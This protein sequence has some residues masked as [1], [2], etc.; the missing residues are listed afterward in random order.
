M[1]QSSRIASGIETRGFGSTFWDV[2]FN[3]KESSTKCKQHVAGQYGM[4]IK[5]ILLN[6][7]FPRF[8]SQFLRSGRA[9]QKEG[10]CHTPESCSCS[11]SFFDVNPILA[12]SM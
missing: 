6:I 3:Y 1:Q 9:S 5:S 12:F 10:G 8:P 11:L 4:I 2:N 7:M